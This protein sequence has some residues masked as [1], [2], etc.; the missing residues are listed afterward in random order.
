MCKPWMLVLRANSHRQ[1]Q[2]LEC[3]WPHRGCEGCVVPRVML[4][5]YNLHISPKLCMA[6]AVSY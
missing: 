3:S 6:P 5:K 4:T 2:V 1:K